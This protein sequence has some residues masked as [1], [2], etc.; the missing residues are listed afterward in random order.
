MSTAF[1]RQV[2]PHIA[3]RKTIED[4]KVGLNGKI[5]I[6]VTAVVGT[7]WCAYVFAVLALAALPSAI[8]SGDPLQLVQWISQTFLQLVLLSVIIV[9]QNI[10]SRS[11]DKRA[12]LTYNDADA[13]FH[14]A[15]QIQDH[16]QAQ[17]DAITS[18]LD[19]LLMLEAARAQT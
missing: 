15:Q 9:G 3:K 6:L 18:I 12:E 19:K 14:E 13:T 2:H 10:A 17:D 8:K 7:M 16:L 5:A 1:E 4:E 11:S